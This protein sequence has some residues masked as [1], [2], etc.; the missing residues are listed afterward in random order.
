[1]YNAVFL[2][3]T[4]RD[5]QYGITCQG[6][7]FY[8]NVIGNFVDARNAEPGPTYTFRTVGIQMGDQR[9][10][11]AFPLDPL[12]WRNGAY[13]VV[14]YNTVTNATAGG[15]VSDTMYKGEAFGNLVYQNYPGRRTLTP[16]WTSRGIIVENFANYTQVH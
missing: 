8:C 13:Q 14:K 3:V 12:H 2:N 10:K 1:S 7:T 5:W 4:S 15:I 6:G 16:T 9:S 11:D